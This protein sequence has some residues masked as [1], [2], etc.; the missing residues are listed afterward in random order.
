MPMSR[1]G[2]VHTLDGSVDMAGNQPLLPPRHY[3]KMNSACELAVV[4]GIQGDSRCQLKE[5]P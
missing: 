2:G 4:Q 3:R 1:R 5:L